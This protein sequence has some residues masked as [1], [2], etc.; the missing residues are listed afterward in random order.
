VGVGLVRRHDVVGEAPRAGDE[1]VILDA[2]LG[3]RVRIGLI[4][5][6][7]RIQIAPAMQHS[8]DF[9][10]RIT[11]SIEYEVRMDNNR[12]DSLD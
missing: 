6:K 1:R 8:D 9:H 3:S 2:R 5:R 11:G 10:G 12:A 7:D 4:I